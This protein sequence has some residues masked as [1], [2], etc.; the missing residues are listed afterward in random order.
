MDGILFAAVSLL[1]LVFL[2]GV[3]TK[4]PRYRA[5]RR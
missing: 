1:L 4:T 3:T 5:R 2:G